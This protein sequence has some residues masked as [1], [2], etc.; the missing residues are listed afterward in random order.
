MVNEDRKDRKGTHS[1]FVDL[2]QMTAD[3]EE[4]S[5]REELRIAQRQ[6]LAH[7]KLLEDIVSQ[8]PVERCGGG[9]PWK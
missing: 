1:K 8:E 3:S 4:R 9:S 6:L 7:T 5:L 2:E